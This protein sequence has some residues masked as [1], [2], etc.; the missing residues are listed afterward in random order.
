MDETLVERSGDS[1]DAEKILI[2]RCVNGWLVAVSVD[3]GSGTV[4]K[5]VFE[6]FDRDY[7]NQLPA[8]CDVLKTVAKRIGPYTKSLGDKVEKEISIE[9]KAK[10]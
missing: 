8:L 9:I 1:A 10:Q 5:M 4:E 3:D 7:D 2:E 6:Y